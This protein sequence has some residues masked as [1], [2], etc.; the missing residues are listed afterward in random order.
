MTKDSE[1]NGSS[2]QIKKLFILLILLYDQPD[3]N[4]DICFVQN[5]L[6][7]QKLR[8]LSLD[9]DHKRAGLNRFKTRLL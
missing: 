5:N 1:P 4:W 2:N 9:R 3:T 8:I 6:N 7:T